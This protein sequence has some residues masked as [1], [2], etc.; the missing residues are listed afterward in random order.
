MLF[1]PDHRLYRRLRPLYR[2]VRP[3]C[4]VAYFDITQVSEIGGEPIGTF[5]WA[6]GG[7]AALLRGCFLGP[8]PMW[9]KSLHDEY[10]M[11]NTDYHSAGD[12]EFWLRL[13]SKGVKFHHIKEVLGAYLV[14]DDSAEKREPLRSTWETA[15]ARGLYR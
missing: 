8:M 10:G 14:R 13:A 11:F 5:Q 7:L 1:I 12:Y 9:R 15:K 6:E 2:Y 4:G 3:H